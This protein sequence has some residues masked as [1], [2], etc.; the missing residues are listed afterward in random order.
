MMLKYLFFTYLLFALISC[1]Q[2]N[3]VNEVKKF[4]NTNNLIGTTIKTNAKIVVPSKIY[5]VDDKLIVYDNSIN[6]IFKVFKLPE[7]EFLYSWGTKGQGP[8][9]FINITDNSMHIYKNKLEILDWQNLKVFQIQND[10]FRLVEQHNLPSLGTPINQLVRINDSIYFADN[11]MIN[12]E[13]FE[14]VI[15]NVKS[16]KVIGKFG[17]YSDDGLIFKNVSERYLASSKSNTVSLING[18][19]S[20]FYYKFNRFKIYG[21]DGKFLKSI[22]L[23]IDKSKDFSLKSENDNI[24]F[25][26]DPL[27]IDNYIYVLFINKSKDEIENDLTNYKPKIQIWDWEGNPILEYVLDK[28]ITAFYV[29][30]WNRKLYGVSFFNMDEIY[31]FDLP[32]SLF[33]KNEKPIFKNLIIENFKVKMFQDWEINTQMEKYSEYHKNGFNYLRH[34]YFNPLRIDNCGTSI[35]ISVITPSDNNKINLETYNDSII[36]N[37][38]NSQADY[39][40]K[41]VKINGRDGYEYTFNNNSIDPRGEKSSNSFSIWL[42]DYKNKLVEISFCSCSEFDKYYDGVFEIV[43]SIEFK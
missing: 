33:L 26:A 37:M 2:E 36:G 28:P 12:K 9:E 11:S 19:F 25:F 21:L 40:F 22:V 32:D 29:S 16:Q 14:H 34:V 17:E 41:R 10:A 39:K 5:T 4:S 13:E 23:D 27:A 7:M 24:I 1:I 18:K 15:L 3:S 8:N 43:S 30:K 31:E 20:T 42:L 6:N 35:S 38:Y